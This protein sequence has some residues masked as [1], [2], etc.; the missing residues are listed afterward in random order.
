MVG[1]WGNS[2]DKCIF[3]VPFYT[4]LHL[5]CSFNLWGVAYI[6][7]Y[8]QCFLYKLFNQE[9]HSWKEPLVMQFISSL[10]YIYQRQLVRESF[11]LS[12]SHFITQVSLI[13][14][15]AFSNAF[16]RGESWEKF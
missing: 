12:K 15:F 16:E 4:E 5:K 10:E 8:L 11:K 13:V 6:K 1:C 7:K 2:L 14:Y 3:E 9:G